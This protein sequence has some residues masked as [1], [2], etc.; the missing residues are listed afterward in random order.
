MSEEGFVKI[1][2]KMISWGWFRDVNTAHLFIYCMMRANY[3]D[4]EWKGVKVKRGSFIT[5]LKHLSLET[6]LTLQQ[7]RTALEHL[8]STQEITKQSSFKNTVIIVN[9]YDKYQ[10]GNTKSSSKSTKYQQ[11]TNKVVTKYQQGTNKVVTTDKKKKKYS[12]PYRD[13]NT[14]AAP[15]RPEGG[16]LARQD[17]PAAVS[18]REIRQYAKD[19]HG[20]NDYNACEFRNAFIASKTAFPEDWKYVYEHFCQADVQKQNDFLRDMAEGK[21]RERWGAAK[22]ES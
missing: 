6:G 18:V 5:S 21:Y 17:E 1:S 14:G 10:D 7:T 8:I 13:E 2:R 12:H 3:K 20:G 4:T 9:N 16:G 22:Y 19:V 11:G 15:A